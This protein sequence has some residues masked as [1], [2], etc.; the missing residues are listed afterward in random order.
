LRKIVVGGIGLVL[1]VS[2]VLASGAFAGG[3][4]AQHSGLSPQ[5]GNNNDQCVIGSGDATNGFVMLNAPGKP[6]DANKLLGEVSLKRGPANADFIVNVAV[7]DGND[8]CVPEGTLH[9]NGVGNGNAH[10]ADTSGLKN[11]SY[12]VVLQNA[13]DMSE[14]FASGDLTVN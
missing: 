14:A 6:G 5:A 9:T 10:I 1:G 7:D 4:G 2:T 12:Y 3:N 11:G 8:N 13:S